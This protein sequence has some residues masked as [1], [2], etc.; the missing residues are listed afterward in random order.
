[1]IEVIKTLMDTYGKVTCSNTKDGAYEYQYLDKALT[2]NFIQFGS[3]R[4]TKALSVDI[5]AHQDIDKVYDTLNKYNIPTPTFIV[6][7]NKGLHLHWVLNKRVNSSNYKASKYR[8]IVN[9]WLV[10]VL[11]GDN[12]AVGFRRNFRN[13]LKHKTIYNDSSYNLDDFKLPKRVITQTKK[14]TTTNRQS[15][16]VDFS[17]VQVGERHEALFNALRSIAYKLHKEKAE[18]IHSELS[19]WAHYFNSELA[20]PQTNSEIETLVD[21]ITNWVSTKYT[22]G[23]KRATEFNRNLAKAKANKSYKLIKSGLITAMI[24]LASI[25]LLRK[26]S[27]RHGG[28]LCGVSKNT[29]TKY[30]LM[31]LEEIKQFLLSIGKT[32]PNILEEVY[33]IFIQTPLHTIQQNKTIYKEAYG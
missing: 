30:K 7:T 31:V 1:L 16:F 10:S 29:F 18:V 8:N 32:I 22:G 24:N 5:D 15:K 21:T 4:F 2:Y 6:Y 13:P 33:N 26:L 20:E 19:K 23:S 3:R 11:E 28:K 14:V 17:K 25:K 27:G 12:R 9:K